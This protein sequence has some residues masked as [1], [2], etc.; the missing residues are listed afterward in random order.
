MKAVVLEVKDGKAIVLTEEGLTK[1]LKY[2]G[3]C[4]DE[5]ELTSVKA[6]VTPIRKKRVAGAIAAAVAV[7]VIAG[8]V[9]SQS[10]TQTDTYVA[11]NE[12][13][14]ADPV[15]SEEARN[16][17]VDTGS[18]LE[19]EN[20]S[21][22]KTDNEVTEE[23]KT[24]EKAAKEE[25]PG[26]TE[27]NQTKKQPAEQTKNSSSQVVAAPLYQMQQ[28]YTAPS[29]SVVEQTLA[30]P[31]TATTVTPSQPSSGSSKKKQSGVV[32]AS[33]ALASERSSEEESTP[34][35]TAAQPASEPV[36]APTTPEA[37]AAA[38]VPSPEPEVIQATESAKQAG[39]ETAAETITEI[40]VDQGAV[41]AG[42][43]PEE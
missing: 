6:S 31:N 15:I 36:I 38:A 35:S 30:N 13:Q 20:D 43:V 2:T 37:P 5:I 24:E 4:G 9:Y 19:S 40:Q 39:G 21:E 8:G 26:E 17:G 34:A 10:L 16:S 42:T 29:V 12:E 32:V 23:K 3:Q 28:Q 1:K 14:E 22:K 27:E 41:N 18:C 33:Q 25:E 7:S 11:M